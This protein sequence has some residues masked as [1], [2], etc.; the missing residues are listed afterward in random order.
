MTTWPSSER[1]PSSESVSP[2]TAWI[3][4]DDVLDDGGALKG[5]HAARRPFPSA[6]DPKLGGLVEDVEADLL[7]YRLSVRFGLIGHPLPLPLTATEPM[8][9]Q[10]FDYGSRTATSWVVVVGG[11]VR[12]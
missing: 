3:G 2:T 6:R 7:I 4:R 1:E 12:S 10:P 11:A 9:T 5:R 8:T